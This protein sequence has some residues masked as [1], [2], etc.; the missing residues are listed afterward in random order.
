LVGLS[1]LGDLPKRGGVDAGAMVLENSED[2][3]GV[4]EGSTATALMKK[5]NVAPH[6]SI[7]SAFAKMTVLTSI[8]NHRD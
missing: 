8:S 6:P 3:G 4:G 2:A 5:R 7:L 1:P